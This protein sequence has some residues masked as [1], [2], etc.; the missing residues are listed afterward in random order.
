MNIDEYREIDFLLFIICAIF[1]IIIML[2][3][4]IAIINE[5]YTNISKDMVETSY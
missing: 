5:V 1:N 4:L 3:L 2:N